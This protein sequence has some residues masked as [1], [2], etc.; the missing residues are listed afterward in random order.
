M[1]LALAMRCQRGWPPLRLGKAP[2]HS[3]FCTFI[4]TKVSLRGRGGGQETVPGLVSTHRS[5]PFEPNMGTQPAKTRGAQS[6]PL[7]LHGVGDGSG[8]PSLRGTVAGVA[9]RCS[10]S[11]RDGF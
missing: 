6:K 2:V 8:G 9:S 5:S 7:T 10:S 3:C 4:L 1:G 11:R